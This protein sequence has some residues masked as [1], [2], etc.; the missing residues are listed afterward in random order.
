MKYLLLLA[1]ILSAGAYAAPGS[2]DECGMIAKGAFTYQKG[3]N[4][5]VD[6]YEDSKTFVDSRLKQFQE[7]SDEKVAQGMPPE[8][9]AKIMAVIKRHTVFI[10]KHIY[11]R[12][13]SA[14]PA[15]VRDHVNAMCL[16]DLD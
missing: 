9:A 5:N 13:S 1:V 2:P 11:I 7:I 12:S 8:R 3:R 15:Q 16:I 4:L 10:A 14:D 6:G